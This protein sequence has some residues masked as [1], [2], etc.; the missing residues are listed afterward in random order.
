MAP[1]QWHVPRGM[2]AECHPEALRL[3]VDLSLSGAGI[4]DCYRRVIEEAQVYGWAPIPHERT[5]RRAVERLS[6]KRGVAGGATRPMHLIGE[7]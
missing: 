4:S 5:L 6:P 1:Q 7:A 3:F 2:L